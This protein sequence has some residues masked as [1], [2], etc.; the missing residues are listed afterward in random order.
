[1]EAGR[2]TGT[3]RDMRRELRRSEEKPISFQS[4]RSCGVVFRLIGGVLLASRTEVA[5]PSSMK[6]DLRDP[7]DPSIAADT[8]GG[9]RNQSVSC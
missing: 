6:V 5:Q 2:R 3:T 7:E 8:V 1:M 9:N 4:A